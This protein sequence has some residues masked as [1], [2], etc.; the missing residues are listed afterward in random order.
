[1]LEFNASDLVLIKLSVFFDNNMLVA[2]MYSSNRIAGLPQITFNEAKNQH[3]T[4]KAY[5][6]SHDWTI[7]TKHLAT[8]FN[9]Q[10]TRDMLKIVG[11]PSGRAKKNSRLE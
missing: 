10:K 9:D 1:M 2:S 5:S 11:S 8:L 7:P 4:K 6:R 3:N